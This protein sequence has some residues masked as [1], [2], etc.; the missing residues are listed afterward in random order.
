MTNL[1]Q[2][3]GLFW[4][5]DAVDWKRS[6]SLL[7]RGVRAKRKGD[8]DFREQRGIYALYDDTFRLVYV[9]QAGRG[10]RR[11]FRRLRS[12]TITDMAERWSRF[13]WFGIVP[14]DEEAKALRVDWPEEQSTKTGS[15]LDHLEAIL[16]TA[17]EPVLNKKGGIFGEGVRNY[18]QVATRDARD[19]MQIVEDDEDDEDKI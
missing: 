2:N 14:V 9:G 16:I 12:H 5:R 7:G 3:Y 8:V 17:A 15:I 18:R 1:I 4:R 10:Q 6:G 19:G 11:L 13:S